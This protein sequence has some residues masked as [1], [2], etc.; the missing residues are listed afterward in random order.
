MNDQIATI[1]KNMESAVSRAKSNLEGLTKTQQE[2][3]E[4]AAAQL[5]KG[6]EEL[7]ALTKEN[8][9]ALVLSGTIVAKGAEEAGKQM[10]AYTQASMEKG[11]AAGKAAFT[12]KSLR[13]LFDLQNAYVKQSVDSFVTESTRMQE[14]SAKIANEAFAPINAR[15]NA[16][17]AKLS[18]PLAA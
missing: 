12:V 16:T 11:V 18:K 17:V 14:L 7:A 2:Q 6:Y 8:V 15:V 1:A 4:K 3:V 9:D 13:E 5:L 10:A